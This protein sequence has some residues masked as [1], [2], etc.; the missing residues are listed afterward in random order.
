MRKIKNNIK[1]IPF[2][3]RWGTRILGSGTN[4]NFLIIGAQ[5]SG[6]TSL[7]NYIN[8]NANNFI[9]PKSKELYFFSERY[10]KGM[11]WYRAHFPFKIKESY[12]TGEATPDYLYYHKSAKRVYENYPNIKFIILLRNPVDRAYSQYNFSK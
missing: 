6:T 3:I 9:P 1:S 12:L 7:F 4:P 8:E 11:P 5:K 10:S 2:K